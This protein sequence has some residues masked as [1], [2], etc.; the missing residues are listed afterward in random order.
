MTRLLQHVPGRQWPWKLCAFAGALIPAHSTQAYVPIQT[1]S[2]GYGQVPSSTQMTKQSMSQDGQTQGRRLDLP[3]LLPVP[4]RKTLRTFH[5]P[6]SEWSFVAAAQAGCGRE[7]TGA[8]AAAGDAPHA[9]CG[10]AVRPR[11]AAAT[12]TMDGQRAAGRHPHPQP[13]PPSL[14]QQAPIHLAPSPKT[15]FRLCGHCT[16][17]NPATPSTLIEPD[18]PVRRSSADRGLS[19]WGFRGLAAWGF[20]QISDLVPGPGMTCTLHFSGQRQRQTGTSARDRSRGGVLTTFSRRHA[21]PRRRCHDWRE[22][23]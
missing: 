11:K 20:P 13:A 19:W 3:A 8:P 14:L 21:M 6:L 17:Q 22:S 7:R 9:G 4:N 1:T 10:N 18:A 5:A 2:K 15:I 16:T 23:P 12:S